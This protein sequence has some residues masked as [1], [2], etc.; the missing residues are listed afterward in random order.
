MKKFVRIKIKLVSSIIILIS[1]I[2]VLALSLITVMSIVGVQKSIAKSKNTI[3][4]AMIAKGKILV[5]NYSMAMTGMAEDNSFTVIQ[6][7]VSATVKPKFRSS[8]P[9]LSIGKHRDGRR[10]VG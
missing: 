9:A 6:S 3:W 2:F 4:K 1:A 5:Q 10:A 7:L 8:Q